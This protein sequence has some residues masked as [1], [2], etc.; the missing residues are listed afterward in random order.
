MTIPE[1]DHNEID[2]DIYYNKIELKIVLLKSSLSESFNL[3]DN[4]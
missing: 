2:R 3:L 1:E 4:L